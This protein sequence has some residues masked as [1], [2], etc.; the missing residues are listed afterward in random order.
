MAPH[1]ARVTGNDADAGMAA[2]ASARLAHTRRMT[3]RHCGFG[4]GW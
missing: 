2:A 4:E 3:I 1:F